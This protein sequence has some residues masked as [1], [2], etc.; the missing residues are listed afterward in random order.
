MVLMEEH[1]P[2]PGAS[3]QGVFARGWTRP[4]LKGFIRINKIK[5]KI[6]YFFSIDVPAQ[7]GHKVMVPDALWGT[8]P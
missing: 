5:E 7:M 2:P 4:P 1:T 6:I 3:S 8:V